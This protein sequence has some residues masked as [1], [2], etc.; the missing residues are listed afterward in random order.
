[1]HDLSHLP[2]L[3]PGQRGALLGSTLL[4]SLLLG[5][6]RADLYR[7]VP[8]GG[9]F[10][11]ENWNITIPADA[12][13]GTAGDAV[14][15]R[16]DQLSGPQGYQGRWF[17]TDTGDGAMT[18]WT[19]INGATV[20]GS[21]SPRSELREVMDPSNWSQTWNGSGTS[22]LDALV[23]VTQV[24]SDGIVIVG[25]VHGYH[26]AP[27]IMIYYRYDHAAGTGKIVAKLQGTPVQGPPY[28]NHTLATD[29]D[30]GEAFSYQLKV[31]NNQAMASVDGGT[32][33]QMAMSP[34]WD[35]ETFY[36][37]AGSYLHLHGTSATEGGRAKF[38]RLAASHPNDGLRISSPAGLPAARAGTL[39]QAQL[40]STGGLGGATWKLVSGHPP[41]GLRLDPDGL[42]TGT[43]EA[44]A[45]SSRAH[46]FMVQVRDVNGSTHAKT[47]SLLVNAAAQ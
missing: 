14:T 41:A 47:F 18:F 12:D 10:A 19:P 6:A 17:N 13:G 38:Y 24:P 31:Q 36:F 23:K 3:S 1:M 4:G 30:L 40:S 15:I 20:G 26:S 39:Y 42:V 44:S 32:P 25:Q 27:L 46:W 7:G 22:V 37:K 29:V 2:A 5:E 43:P 35:G 8:P 11:L 21:T 34:A 9:N 33:A 28:T 45:V 16:P